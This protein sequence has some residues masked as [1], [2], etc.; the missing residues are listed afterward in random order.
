MMVSR[1]THRSNTKTLKLNNFAKI[2]RASKIVLGTFF[3]AV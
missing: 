2:E 3:G 1:E